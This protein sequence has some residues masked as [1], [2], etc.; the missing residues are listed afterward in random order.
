MSEGK[1]K[2]AVAKESRVAEKEGEVMTSNK[3]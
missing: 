2:K 3:T 1:M